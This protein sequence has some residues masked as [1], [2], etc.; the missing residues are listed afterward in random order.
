[1]RVG[2]PFSKFGALNNPSHRRSNSG[3][4]NDWKALGALTLGQSVLEGVNAVQNDGTW[5][6]DMLEN[7]S[8]DSVSVGIGSE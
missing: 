5:K 3:R 7:G 6:G 8:T 1:M 2:R 4:D